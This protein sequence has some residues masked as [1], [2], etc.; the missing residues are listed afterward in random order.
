MTEV[1]AR[2]TA[3]ETYARAQHFAADAVGT[4]AARQRGE[5]GGLA[6]TFGVIGADFLAATAYALDHRAHG[7]ET[8]ARRHADQGDRTRA[9][10][11]AYTDDD[12]SSATSIR[13]T[14]G[15]RGLRL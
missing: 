5:I 1:T 8:V 10:E 3:L 15:D 6:T 7:L 12:A 9:A 11:I 14:V 13:T 4:Q 2:P